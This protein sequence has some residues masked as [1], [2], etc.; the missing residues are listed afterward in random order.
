LQASSAL[1]AK[2]VVKIEGGKPFAAKKHVSLG[3]SNVSQQ[4]VPMTIIKCQSATKSK[5]ST[6]DFTLSK[7]PMLLMRMCPKLIRR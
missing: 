6:A 7:S 2:L 3:G 5:T 1:K 4:I